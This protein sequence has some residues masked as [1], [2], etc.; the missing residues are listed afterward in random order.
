MPF[1][2]VRSAQ[3]R[4]FSTWPQ[5]HPITKPWNQRGDA[6]SYVISKNLHRRHLNESQMAMVAAKIESFRHGDNQHT[7]GDTNRHL[8][9]R[10]EDFKAPIGVLKLDTAANLLNVGGTSVD[11]ASKVRARGVPELQAAVESG[12]VSLSSAA[13]G[14]DR[15]TPDGGGR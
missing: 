11:R 4:P 13:C 5:Q 12:S 7:G 1:F 2:R 10:S 3:G 15:G 9:K 6:L 8:L 14:L